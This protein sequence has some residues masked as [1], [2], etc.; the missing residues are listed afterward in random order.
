MFW[1]N[2]EFERTHIK[3]QGTGKGTTTTAKNEVFIGFK[4]EKIAT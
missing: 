4:H 1:V 3:K 2:S